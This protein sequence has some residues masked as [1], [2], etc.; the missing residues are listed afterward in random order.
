MRTLIVALWVLVSAAGAAADTPLVTAQG[1]L[2]GDAAVAAATG[3]QQAHAAARGGDHVLVVWSDQR[4]RAVGGSSAQGD[5]DIFGLRVDAAGNPV[6]AAPFMVAGGMGLQ[7]RPLVAWNGSAWLVV[8]R[9]QDPVG[10]YF[11]T[12]LRAVRIAADGTRLDATPLTLTPGAFTPDDIGLQV[13]GGGGQWLVT[14]CLYHEDG[15]GTYLAGQRVGANGQLL[16]GSPVMLQD[17]VYGRT[18]ALWAGGEFLVAGPEWNDSAVFRARRVGAGGQPVGASF[19]IPGLELASNGSEYYVTWVADY[20]NLVG[21]RMTTSGTLLNPAGTLLAGGYTQFHGR[22]LAHDGT[23]WWLAWGAADEWRTVRVSAAGAV[24]DSGGGALL[25]LVIGGT[26]NNAYAA[27][28]V[29]RQGGGVHFLWHD[30]RV[31]LGNDSNVFALPLSPTNAPGSERCV[32]TGTANQREPDMAAGP[33]GATAIVYVSEHANDDRVLLQLLAA[34]GQAAGGPVLVASGPTIGT[35][36][37]AWDGQR[38]MVAWDAGTSGLT[39]T[40]VK[41]RRLAADGA[42]IDAVPLE[43]MAGFDPDLEALG[44]DFL[45]AAAR[46]SANPQYIDAWMRIVDGGTGALAGDPA[47]L[48]SGYVSVGPRVRSDGS[49]W[50]V[51]Y[52]SHWSHNSSASDVVYNFVA[53]DGSFTPAVN[54]T[55]TSGGGGTPDVAFSGAAYLFVW[56]SNTLA[57]ADNYISGRLMAANGTFLTGDFTIA[58]APGRQLRPSVGWDGTDFLVVWDDQRNQESFYDGRTDIY[59]ARVNTAGVVLDTDGFVVQA[60]GEGDATAA[61]LCRPGAPS[62]VAWATFATDGAPY[63]SWRVQHALVGPAALSSVLPPAVSGA[64]R[65]NVPNPFNPSTR[66]AF[67]L[68]GAGAARLAVYDLRGRL[69]RTLLDTSALAAGDH[70]VTWDGRADDGSSAAAGAYLYDL[71]GPGVREV[72][73]MTLAK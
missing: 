58:Q 42:F 51:T 4:G 47:R 9:S 62:R 49:R 43:V 69:V 39:P 19:T 59:G 32:S 45:V 16:D 31:A 41:A 48:L 6:D 17:W 57:N 30:Q 3:S 68:P 12:R 18:V 65:Q 11:E 5:G 46:Y 34:N 27:Q 61:L 40:Q 71:R 29:S 60:D 67:T 73:R 1:P 36:A 24:L 20:V 26:V 22:T 53:P 37:V 55:T 63:D 72:R 15:Y 10:G 7:D 70:A 28:L 14:R 44:G 56:R 2:Q 52:H 8:Y 50:L 66:I 54:P 23:N 25:P 21:S 13:A 33:G 35:A 64:L 38:Y